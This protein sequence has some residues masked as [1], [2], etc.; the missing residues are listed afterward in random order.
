MVKNIEREKSM[1]KK[2]LTAIAVLAG[3]TIFLYSLMAK[4]D[5]RDPIIIT[6]NPSYIEMK[7]D[8][9]IT[10]AD[11]IVIGNPNTINPS[12][13]NT[14]DGKLPR[15]TTVNTISPNMVIFTDVIFRIED[16]IKGLVNQNTV[17]I[18][19]VGGMVGEDKMIVSGIASLEMGKSYLLFL[20][21]DTTGGTANIDPGHYFVRGGLQGLY[22]IFGGKAIS[23][24]EEWQLEELIAYIQKSLSA[25]ALLPTLT[26]AP[27]ELLIETLTPSPT[28]TPLPTET[29]TPTP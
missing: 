25:E 29:T 15:G 20:G 2:I 9:L 12:R 6:S 19:S 27:T 23:L 1:N 28:Q 13:W 8:Y 21:E 4:D 16:T 17:R 11:L 26:P 14:P 5:K 7:L 10:E 3:L 18:R 22:E 24:R